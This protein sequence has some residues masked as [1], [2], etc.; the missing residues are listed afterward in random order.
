MA[1][2]LLAQ[3]KIRIR[4]APLARAGT[5]RNVLIFAGLK[6]PSFCFSKGKS[7]KR[8]LQQGL[9]QNSIFH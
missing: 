2:S 6:N 9:Y 4:I 7:E 8:G 5:A 1:V 3:E